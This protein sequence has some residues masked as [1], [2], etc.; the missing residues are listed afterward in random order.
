[1]HSAGAPKSVIN[2]CLGAMFPH[3]AEK[4]SVRRAPRLTIDEAREL[5]IATALAAP[6]G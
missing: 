4:D 5:E 2:H 3:A 1:V 6:D